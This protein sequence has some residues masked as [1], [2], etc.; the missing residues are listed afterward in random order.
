MVLILTGSVSVLRADEAPYARAYLDQLNSRLTLIEAQVPAI[1][2]AAEQAAEAINSGRGDRGD[3]GFGVRGDAG[4]ANELSN[5]AGAMLG[6][7]GRAGD[8]GDVIVYVFGVVRTDGQDM[9]A[10]L[11]RQLKDAARLSSLGSTVIGLGS[12]AQLRSLG[13]LDE[14]EDAC[15]VLLDNTVRATER[16]SLNGLDNADAPVDTV[17][18]ASLAWA[19]ECELFSACTR[20]DRVP[21][22]RQSFE[23]DTRKRRWLRYGSQRFHDDRWLDPIPPG[24]LGHAYL[25][26]LREVLLDIGTASWRRIARTAHRA[27]DSLASGGTVW[28]RAGGRYLPYHFGGQLASDPGVFTALNHDGSD[29]RLAVPGEDDFVIAVGDSETAGSY[30]WGE[31]ELLR[32]AGRGVAWIVNG[33]NTQPRDL[34]RRE[35]MV[36]LWA[37]FGDGVV[38]VK[39]YDARLGPVTGVVGE[40]VTW[41]IT[42]EVVGEE[43]GESDH[44]DRM[45]AKADFTA[46]SAQ[47]AEKDKENQE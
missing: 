37:P 33:Y 17:L 12:V 41:M 18:N 26:G 45:K 6:Y 13:H 43:N 34:Y 22:V 30:E 47:G 8:P 23:I 35:I 16:L 28:L 4:L 32:G 44:M 40:A 29:S 1:T 42:A 46:E 3:R 10:L 25:D 39:N 24:K 27:Q 7:D 2:K 11:T 21:V 5:R 38:R 9:Q 14:A 31:P 19:F 20:L 15:A 36:D